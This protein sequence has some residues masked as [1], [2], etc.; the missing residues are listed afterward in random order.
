MAAYADPMPVIVI[1]ADTPTGRAVVDA[2]LPR[3][4]EVRA[5]VSDPAEAAALKD[6]GVKVAVGDVSDGS[7]I[8]GAASRAF[9]AVAVVAA[10]AD[11]RERS[12]AGDPQAV[13]DAWREGLIDA[14][15]ARVIV[16]EDP[17]VEAGVTRFGDAE[18]VSVSGH[19]PVAE[20][21]AEVSRLEGLDRL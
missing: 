4:G 16:V 17:G 2:L 14:G 9:C 11:D 13:L 8:G 6:R 19:L 1:G 3:R 10:A 7:H 5:F 12:F 21:A 20:I 15:V 18:L